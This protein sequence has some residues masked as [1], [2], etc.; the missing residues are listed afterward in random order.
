MS[1]K[2]RPEGVWQMAW[3][4][5]SSRERRMIWVMLVIAV[6]GAAA[7]VL[8]IGSIMPFLTVLSNPGAISENRYLSTLYEQ[9]RFSSKYT[10]M[11]YLGAGTILVIILAN[12]LLVVKSY[13]VHRFTARRVHSIS[14]RL[15]QSYLGREYDFFLDKNS[16]D[17]S[18][19]VL[20][21]AN[22]IGTAFLTPAVN[23]LTSGL[24]M[25]GI[26]GF[27]LFINPT[28]TLLGAGSIFLVYGII[29]AIVSGRLK[30]LGERLVMAN[31]ERFA[32]I[33]E[34]VGGI[35][36]IKI[37]GKED[38]FFRRFRAASSTV[39]D[40]TIWHRVMSE[41]PRFAIQSF[42]FSGVVILCLL[43]IDS[44]SFGTDA[45]AVGRIVPM[46][47]AFAL[48]GQRLMPEAQ[49]FYKGMSS[50]SFG[51]AEVESVYRD[52]S[53]ENRNLASTKSGAPMT[54]GLMLDD[55]SYRYPGAE[56]K[57]LS[58]IS[59]EI[60]K[61]QKIGVVG[62]TGSGKSTLA[63]ICLG[64]ISPSTGSFSVDGQE[65]S[66]RSE[67]EAWRSCV[68]Y[69]PQDIF[70][71]DGTFAE[72]IA[73]GEPRNRVDFQKVEDCA[74]IARLHEVVMAS[75]KKGYDQQ[76]GERGV[77]LSGGQKQRIGIAR[78]LYRGANVLVMDEATS[79]L[80]NSTERDVIAAIEALPKDMTVI[81][82]AHRLSTLRCCDEIITLQKGQITDRGDWEA[83]SQKKGVFRDM[84]EAAGL[85][86][87][88]D[89]T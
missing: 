68:A 70:I 87:A 39:S 85:D 82:I 60:S 10:F 80:D 17:I 84:L 72:N 2:K 77:R 14:V 43:M 50:M 1:S 89:P 79:A 69:V 9:F 25:I 29:Y 36:D 63:D 42:F 27:L 40:V 81:M 57:S 16:S 62:G 24:S 71:L 11:A 19:R 3:R 20:T 12:S 88:S 67:R 18:K 33:G 49:K 5:L 55:V 37:L 22:A 45:N 41:V 86:R 65:I 30:S 52:M 35:K 59:L 74:R 23:I 47:G 66:G 78:A 15:A 64:L 46:L 73:F 13:A 38:V 76:V 31:K 7:Q 6:I 8:M 28:V 4:M 21:E 53:F 83:L 54:C 61:G 56:P 58:G 34:A 51:S 26:I 75:G 44:D 32:S 48:A